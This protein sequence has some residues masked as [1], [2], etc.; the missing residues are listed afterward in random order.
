MLGLC[1][2]LYMPHLILTQESYQVGGDIYLVFEM[3]LL[4]VMSPRLAG[5]IS[6][7]REPFAMLETE[8]EWVLGSSG[9]EVWK[10][11]GAMSLLCRRKGN[12][13]GPAGR[14]TGSWP[15]ILGHWYN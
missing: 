5:S 4:K 1:Y 13:L 7:R 8:P 11:I 6:S 9:Y 3:Q 10:A 12:Q 2:G 15:V 14:E